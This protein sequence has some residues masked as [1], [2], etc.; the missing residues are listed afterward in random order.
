MRY[1]TALTRIYSLPDSYHEVSILR[2]VAG[3]HSHLESDEWRETASTSVERVRCSLVVG[4][5][6]LETT[7]VRATRDGF[8]SGEDEQV[9]RRRSNSTVIVA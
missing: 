6:L 9:I 7:S 4:G 1:R 2:R 3:Y 8:G 5:G